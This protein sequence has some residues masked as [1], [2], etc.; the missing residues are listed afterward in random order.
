M[1]TRSGRFLLAAGATLALVAGWRIA[2]SLRDPVGPRPPGGFE[3]AR[4]RAAYR[5]S[6]TCA[7]CHPDHAASWGRTFHRT[8]TQDPTP[9]AI[10][11]PFDGRAIEAMGVTSTVRRQGD[12]FFIDTPDPGSDRAVAHRVD[13]VT[14]SRRM[15]QFESK[16]DDRFVRLPIAWSIA[17][18][19]WFHLAEAFFHPDGDDFHAHRAV[20]DLN[21]IFCH[22]TRP[23]PGLDARERLASR[24]AELGVACEACHGPGEEHARRM[25]S[26]LRRYAMRFSGEDDPTIVNPSHLS[27]ERS[28]Q[29]CGHCHGQRLPVDRN[30]I[31]EILA[32]GDPYR[33]GEDLSRYFEPVTRETNLG[34]FSFATRFWGDGSPRLTAYEYQ[35]M[36][37][38]PCYL[39]GTM[40]C[41]S[42]HTMHDGDPRGQIRADRAGDS[43]C[44]QC[45]KAYTGAKLTA[46]SKHAPDGPGS[47][48]VAC[49]M[50]PVV[51]G[52]MSWHP[53]HQISSP[54]PAAAARTGTP[55]ACTL[56]HSGRSR[57]WA[58]KRPAG[59][60]E[61]PELVH[62]L[63]A[64]DAVYRTLAAERLGH[65]S[66]DPGVAERTVPL[67]AELLLD[68][69]PAVRRTAREALARLTGRADLP[70]ALDTLPLRRAERA[71]LQDTAR[72]PA[73]EDGWPF[74]AAGALDRRRLAE[75]KHERREAEVSIGE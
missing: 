41:L 63:F 48:C 27:K 21:C 24:P 71:R 60:S 9:A 36:L 20:W 34:A 28:V 67:L 59:R 45:H 18:R 17:E 1:A 61:P 26:P 70:G 43:L 33:P 2:A 62:A 40:T 65:P 4:A 35:G 16:S 29:V 14:G 23:V 25:R 31:R 3:A 50:P 13:R 64:G 39:R 10:Q 11:A 74:T 55:D 32:Q 47:R 44:T 5:T 52:I 66:P 58:A 42:C 56:C 49:H 6:K 75:W 68:P 38:S 15:Q 46:H 7:P 72:P 22:T 53:S 69:Y 12:V 19:R 30:A 51:Y 57:G 54:D 8:M 37:R 73:A